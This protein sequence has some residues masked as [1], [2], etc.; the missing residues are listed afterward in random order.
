MSA[1]TDALR[2]SRGTLRRGKLS[3]IQVNMG[4][5]CNQRCAHCHVGAS[6]QGNRVMTRRVAEGIL[7]LLNRNQGLILDLTGGAPELN[8]HF[9]YL[10]TSAR[11]LVRELI[12]RSNLTAML[13]P[14]KGHL[15]GLFER[16]RIHL[17]CS[18]PCYTRENVDRQRGEGVFDRSLEALRL[19]NAQGYGRETDLCLDL[20]H[21]PNGAYLPPE[22]AA[23][24]DDYRRELRAQ[25]G[26]VFNRLL[27]I[28]NVAI[29]RFGGSLAGTGE[30]EN[31]ARLLAENFNPETLESLMCRYLVSA[32]YD[33][34]LYDCDFNQVLGMALTNRWGGALTIGALD[35]GE[36]EGREIAFG[37]H[38]FS[39]AAGLGSSCQ[40][41][42]AGRACAGSR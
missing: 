2:S 26:I 40:G 16:N 14:G 37:D 3:T 11:P 29:G 41:A 1:F 34:N 9:E 28:T 15:P 42:L 13:E 24:E 35:V 23:L 7:A 31:Y 25:Q 33:G 36:M 22:P 17:I 6:P 19:L 4:D 12:V 32:G 38:C 10:L 20:V 5:L 18:L 30:G 39:C 8:P 27:T 21:N